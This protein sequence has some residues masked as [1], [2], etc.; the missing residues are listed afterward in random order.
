MRRGVEKLV[1]RRGSLLALT[2]FC[3]QTD[4]QRTPLKGALGY[5]AFYQKKNSVVGRK[6][7]LLT[8]FEG[9]FHKKMYLSN[10]IFWI[11]MRRGIADFGWRG[12]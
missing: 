5:V 4:K 8:P 7:F 3:R 9:F 1:K 11:I 10:L 2:Q 12:P 6:V